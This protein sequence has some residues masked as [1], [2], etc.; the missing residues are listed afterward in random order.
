MA[1]ENVTL[2]LSLSFHTIFLS[3]PGFPL[4]RHFNGGGNTFAWC[5]NTHPPNRGRGWKIKEIS[6]GGERRVEWIFIVVALPRIRVSITKVDFISLLSSFR[7]C[8]VQ[9]GEWLLCTA[10]CQG[11]RPR[12]EKRNSIDAING[13]PT[14]GYSYL[15]LLSFLICVHFLDQSYRRERGRMFERAN[16]ISGIRTAALARND[17]LLR[18]AR[19]TLSA[20]SSVC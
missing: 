20:D 17:L 14:A 7:F 4:S 12:N 13:I 15:D 6:R 11:T 5:A 19:D 16:S 3:T 1:R 18:F 10:V 9:H 8:S 2:F